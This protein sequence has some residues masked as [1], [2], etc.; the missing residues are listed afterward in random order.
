MKYIYLIL[1]CVL[2]IF[3]C[4]CKSRTSQNE[5]FNQ[6]GVD[7]VI[8]VGKNS[9]YFFKK[10]LCLKYII[11]KDEIFKKDDGF[12]IEISK[13]FIGI[14]K[15][16]KTG[17]LYSPN[18]IAFLTDTEVYLYNISGKRVTK[19][20]I[21]DMFDSFF[22]GASCIIP[23]TSTETSKTFAVFNGDQFAMYDDKQSK[24][25][26]I[27]DISGEGL[28]D[29]FKNVDAGTNWGSDKN[30]YIYYFFK[31]DSFIIYKILKNS[32]TDV[33]GNGKINGTSSGQK[34]TNDY[35]QDIDSILNVVDTSVTK[36]PDNY[37][38]EPNK[39]H[40]KDEHGRMCT[41]NYNTDTRYPN[42]KNLCEAP[43]EKT[44]TGGIKYNETIVLEIFPNNFMGEKDY[45]LKWT[46]SNVFVFEPEMGCI[47][48]NLEN[49][50]V[51]WNENVRLKNV[52]TQNYL[53]LSSNNTKDV[54]RIQK[55]SDVSVINDEYLNDTDRFQLCIS[56]NGGKCEFF[57]N[58]SEDDEQ[59][60]KV[61]RTDTANALGKIDRQITGNNLDNSTIIDTSESD[62]S[63][64]FDP[65]KE[66]YCKED[67]SD[68]RGV[69]NKT[70]N[71]LKCINW[72]KKHK[73]DPD[74]GLGN[75]NYCRNPIPLHDNKPQ[76]DRAWCYVDHPSKEWED[77]QLGP[78]SD[79]CPQTTHEYNQPN[80]N[81][82]S[83]NNDVV[84]TSDEDSKCKTYKQPNN[85][86]EQYCSQI[87][88]DYRGTVNWTK[89]NMQ[90][91]IWPESWKHA[92][93][94]EGIGNHNYCR[95]PDN[96]DRPWC[97]VDDKDKPTR[98]CLVGQPQKV[99]DPP[100]SDELEFYTTENG[101]DYKG[102]Q[103][104]TA[105]GSKC[106]KWN[107]PDLGSSRIESWNH[108]YCRNPP[109]N[110]KA[111]PWCFVKNARTPWEFCSIRKDT[112]ST[113]GFNNSTNKILCAFSIPEANVY[114]LFKSIIINN[115]K[116]IMFNMITMTTHESKLIGIVNDITWPG[117]QFKENIDAAFY[118]NQIIY[119]F[120]GANVVKYD[121]TINNNKTISNIKGKMSSIGSE[122]PN[123]DFK[124]NID[125]II[126]KHKGFAY[127]IKENKYIQ[128]DFRTGRSYTQ[129][130]TKV[131]SNFILNLSLSNIDAAVTIQSDPNTTYAYLFKD[132]Y[133]VEVK[134]ILTENPKELSG[135]ALLI[136]NK[137]KAFWTININNPLFNK[138]E[139]LINMNT[140]ILKTYQ[141]I[142]KI[143][144]AGGFN[145]YLDK[146]KSTVYDI[147][148]ILNISI[149]ELLEL[150]E[151]K[152]FENDIDNK[153]DTYN[154]PYGG[155]NK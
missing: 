74:N 11:S 97:F 112:S 56:N 28:P 12:P 14:T 24:L 4:V 104:T 65:E 150:V 26:Q 102:Y 145:Q 90:C 59:L 152:L 50:L 13:E 42:C 48:S 72:S 131:D 63:Y 81:I 22:K 32:K 2:I 82:Y 129:V 33:F 136:E 91:N 128:F 120:N 17:F 80:E 31:G 98:E 116:Y 143:K 10:K 140:N 23:F 108:N 77:C 73:N 154:D 138:Q 147:A 51:L 151:S 25:L 35:W 54:Y 109:N 103:T 110:L 107:S 92:Y 6:K 5:P 67:G 7:C 30:N 21:E 66:H 144:S 127:I 68:Y 141:T 100:K 41:L 27:R 8:N 89:D 9:V 155:G 153:A 106:S 121:I 37:S 125:C 148:Q 38:L 115:N 135:A 94:N 64:N 79:H 122:F 142:S 88:K 52:S 83:Y 114:Y 130:P 93:N 123:L 47:K 45:P 16:I 15:P 70:K 43:F 3:V 75:H 39:I 119:F 95:N 105:K 99:C 132:N 118:D 96:S 139:I 53:R 60:I 124:S 86:L 1:L 111:M 76:R 18:E 85:E 40:C 58:G 101:T 87:G 133:Y 36:C 149:E 62:R 71:G 19:Y 137:Y 49:R 134:D 57:K 146:T 78:I 84:D 46:K 44:P 55:S 61:F 113:C 69:V 117:L 29:F 126:A 20:L 34:I